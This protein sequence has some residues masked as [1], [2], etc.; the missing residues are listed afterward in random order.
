MFFKRIYITTDVVQYIGHYCFDRCF[1][2][3]FPWKLDDP[4]FKYGSKIIPLA[5]W[6]LSLLMFSPTLSDNNG[7]FALECQSMIC[8]W[9]SKDSDGNP[10]GYDPEVSGQLAIILVAFVIVVL[11]LATYIKVSVLYHRKLKIN[12]S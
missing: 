1:L 2:V 3:F 12:Y 10:T 9:I 7:Q 11:N 6:V 5:G 8:R 4:I